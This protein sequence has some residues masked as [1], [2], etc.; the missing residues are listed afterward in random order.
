M[1]DRKVALSDLAAGYPASGIR[2]MFELAAKYD[3]VIKLTVGEPNFDTPQYIKDAAKEALDNGMVHYTPN[4][5]MWELRC[6][7]ADIYKKKY[8]EG[9][10]ADN[11][12]I[13]CGA[14]QA[15][16]VTLMALVNPGDE[17]LVPDPCFSNY[18]GQIC[19]VGA[20]VVPVPTYEENDFRVRAADIEK[21]ITPKSKLLLL[22]SPCNPTGAVLS[23]E[24]IYEIAEVVKKHDL[25]VLSDEPYDCIVFDG[26]ESFSMAQVADVRDRVFVVNSFSKAYAMTGWR[27]G[28]VLVPDGFA[29]QFAHMNEGIISCVPGFIQAAACRALERTD[30]VEEML[31]EYARRRDLLVNG[32]NQIPGFRCKKVPG[33]FYAFPNIT[34]FGKTSEEFAIELLEKA[35]VVVVPGSAFGDMGEGYIRMVFANS[36]ENLK[37]AL[38]RIS[39]YITKA[40]PELN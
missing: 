14:C 27:I 11:V 13:T 23:K 25:V 33:S 1:M 2:K 28:Y 20:K 34:A 8:W 39:E 37:E 19:D 32:L 7:V 16:L 24:D 3:D 9:Y 4:A 36:D 26:E 22:N 30:C 29:D 35:R 5:G 17:V 21:L 31:R 15:I 38:R 12:V 6:K 18:F 10:T 40:Y